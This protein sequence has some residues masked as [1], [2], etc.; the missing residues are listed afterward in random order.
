MC[1][2]SSEPQ[3]GPLMD[4]GLL[5]GLVTK[6][7]LLQ[8]GKALRALQQRSPGTPGAAPYSGGD[9]VARWCLS[10]RGFLGSALPTGYP[11]ASGVGGFSGARKLRAAQEFWLG[12]RAFPPGPAGR[13]LAA[14]CRGSTA[15]GRVG[16]LRLPLCALAGLALLRAA[17]AL[18]NGREDHGSPGD[19]C[20]RSWPG[21]CPG[22]PSAPPP[23]SSE[24]MASEPWSWSPAA[25][26]GTPARQHPLRAS[27]GLSPSFFSFM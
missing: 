15:L 17:G 13:D 10:S 24:R 19:T 18:A 16:T 26:G 3:W 9:R 23:T 1:N 6:A 8:P 27:P 25:G 20:W 7:F 21:I 22:D 4:K 5:L 12:L 14:A 2:G 11:G